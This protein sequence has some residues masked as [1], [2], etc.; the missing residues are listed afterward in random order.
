MYCDS[1]TR[2]RTNFGLSELKGSHDMWQISEISDMLLSFVCAAEYCILSKL[3]KSLKV[4][5]VDHDNHTVIPSHIESHLSQ[6]RGEALE[7]GTIV[8]VTEEQL[9]VLQELPEAE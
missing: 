8:P 9:H 6:H 2:V 1:T 3:F 7:D 5:H 4:C